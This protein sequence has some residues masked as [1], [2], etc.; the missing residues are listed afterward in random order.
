VRRRERWEYLGQAPRIAWD[1]LVRGQYRFT[2][3][4]MPMVVRGM[5][6]A[7][8]LNLMAAGLNLAHRR[9]K[10]SSRPLHMQIELTSVCELEC[11]VC[12]TGVGELTRTGRAIDLDLF[13][14]TLREV[15]PYLLTLS[16]WAWGEPLLYKRLHEA[17]E[18]AARYPAVTLLSTH[19]QQ[20]ATDRVQHAMR[21]HPPSCLIVAIL[22]RPEVRV[23]GPHIPER[24]GRNRQQRRPD[25]GRAIRTG[26]VVRVD[27]V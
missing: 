11:P 22:G 13:E 9:L 16:L 1:A 27:D 17:L 26:V 25:E 19:G 6:P 2:F 24:L 12:P 14:Q 15:G 23:E 3:D 10:P 7:A 4:T 8:R 5:S 20:L 18:I 21:Q